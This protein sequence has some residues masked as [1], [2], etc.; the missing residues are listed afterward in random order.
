M[1]LCNRTSVVSLLLASLGSS[2]ASIALPESVLGD[3]C[4]FDL[5]ASACCSGCVKSLN[6]P[7]L[8]LLLA[9]ELLCLPLLGLA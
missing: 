8:L 4:D 5:S 3:G 6:A 7:L 9:S 1:Q 2:A